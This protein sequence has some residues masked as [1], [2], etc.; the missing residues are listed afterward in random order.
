MADIQ[1]LTV[2]LPPHLPAT[3]VCSLD[4]FCLSAIAALTA[5]RVQGVR[6]EH[7]HLRFPEL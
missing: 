3:R 6:V 5:L 4:V 7:L 2:A 1:R